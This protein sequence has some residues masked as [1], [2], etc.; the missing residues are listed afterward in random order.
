M[1]AAKD[2]KERR[3]I[4][5]KLQAKM[6]LLIK[7]LEITKFKITAVSLSVFWRSQCVQT[8]RCIVSFCLSDSHKQT[9]HFASNRRVD[10][11]AF[12][13]LKYMV[14]QGEIRSKLLSLLLMQRIKNKTFRLV[15]KKKNSKY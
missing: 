14:N 3:K 8:E 7:R 6:W 1:I 15:F 9:F 4:I 10:T 11:K 5:E 12:R 2:K 13:I